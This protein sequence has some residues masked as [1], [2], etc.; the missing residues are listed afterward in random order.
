MGRSERRLGP[1]VRR[2]VG[3]MHLVHLQG[4]KLAEQSISLQ[5]TPPAV[6]W[7]L[8]CMIFGPEDGGDM[9]LRDVGSHTDHRASISQTMAT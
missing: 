9:F 1:Y 8:A 7:L 4:E 5:P 6:R 2:R 3:G